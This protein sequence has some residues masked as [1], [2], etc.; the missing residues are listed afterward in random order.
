MDFYRVKES[1][2]MG[3]VTWPVGAMR[4]W[5]IYD[6]GKFHSDLEAHFKFN[7]IEAAK[8]FNDHF[9]PLKITYD[10]R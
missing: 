5:N 9:E 2:S 7:E 10:P 8:F 3:S 1:F 6:V 4:A